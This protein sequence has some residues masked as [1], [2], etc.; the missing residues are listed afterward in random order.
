MHGGACTTRS[1]SSDV[2]HE[3]GHRPHRRVVQLDERTEELPHLGVG[4]GEVDVAAPDPRGVGHLAAEALAQEAEHRRGLRVVDRRRSRSGLRAAARCRG[5]SRGRC[6]ASAG[7]HSMS[8]PCK[9]LCTALVT[10]KNSSL[11]CITCQSASMPTLRSSGTWVASSSATPPP[12]AVALRCSTRAPCSGCGELADPFDDVDARRRPRSR[13]GAFRA[14]GH[15]RARRLRWCDGRRESRSIYRLMACRA[16]VPRQVQGHAH[17]P[18]RPRRAMAAG[19]RRA[20][21][22][23]RASSCRSPTAARAR[24]TRC[25]RRAAARAVTRRVTGPLGDPVDAEWALL[26]GGVAVVEMA[27][28]SGL[29]LV[30]RSQ[31]SVA[32]VDARHR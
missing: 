15:G 9:P 5:P 29:A 25:S 16:R 21:L 27:R 1:M 6:A 13:R 7:V 3:L 19:L 4:V 31:R 2:G 14:A 20:G 11:P 24:S 12:Y 17:A 32:R 10:A 28:A 30:P 8:A 18:P 26:P 23:R 22:R